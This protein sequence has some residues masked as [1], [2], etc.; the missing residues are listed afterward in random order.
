MRYR[1]K[2]TGVEIT[3]PCEIHGGEWEPV[4]A[5]TAPKA[6]AETKEA[7]PKRSTRGGAK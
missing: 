4:E 6:P 3:V 7:K 2:L 5:P 1:H